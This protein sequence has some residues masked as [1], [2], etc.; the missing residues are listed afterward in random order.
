[1]GGRWR[2]RWRTFWRRAGRDLCRADA[3]LG[4]FE[5]RDSGLGLPNSHAILP[6]FASRT[7]VE[8]RTQGRRAGSETT[9]C[10]TSGRVRLLTLSSA[11][12]AVSPNEDYGTRQSVAT[13][14]QRILTA[15]RENAD[16]AVVFTRAPGWAIG[17]QE[18]AITSMPCTGFRGDETFPSSAQPPYPFLP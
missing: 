2:C 7:R 12:I 15:M 16:Y 14:F 9:A 5:R 10:T 3:G 4:P 11:A 6:Q 13:V 8:R 17:C 1:V 18:R